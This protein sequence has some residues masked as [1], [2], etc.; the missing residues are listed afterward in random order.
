MPRPKLGPPPIPKSPLRKTEAPSDK[1]VYPWRFVIGQSIYV[2]PVENGHVLRDREEL[3]DVVGG[4]LWMG[5]P[6][7]HVRDAYGVTWRVP[8]IHCSSLPFP[9]DR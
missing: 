6:H 8:Q 5:A 9:K 2:L 4:E 7:L 1:R 3:V